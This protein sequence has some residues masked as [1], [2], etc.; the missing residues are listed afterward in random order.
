[1]NSVTSTS[2]VLVRPL[3]QGV[4]PWGPLWFGRPDCKRGPAPPPGIPD[5]R[6]RCTFRS[7]ACKVTSLAMA[8][9][10]VLE[11]D[12]STTGQD[13]DPTELNAQLLL[14]DGYEV[15]SGVKGR[16]M[17]DIK[18][19]PNGNNKPFKWV[20]LDGQRTLEDLRAALA[21]GYPVLVRVIIPGT[22]SNFNHSVL[23][24]GI[25]PGT[26]KFTIK[27]PGWSQPPGPYEYLDRYN[28][29]VYIQG[30]VTANPSQPFATSEQS[31]LVSPN[32]VAALSVSSGENIRLMLIDPAGRRT[33]F[34]SATQ[35]EVN[36]IPNSSYSDEFNLDPETLD[37]QD[38][39]PLVRTVSVD[40]PMPG[41]Y[42]VVTYGLTTGAFE[43]DVKIISATGQF[44]RK[45]I[46][47]NIEAGATVNSSFDFQPNNTNFDYDADGRA[48]L[49]VRRPADGNWYVLRGTAGYMVMTFGVAGDLMVP[50]D[51]DGDGKTDIAMFRPSNGT[52]Y[53]FNSQSQSFSTVGWGASGD[54]PV[55][56]DHDGDG[57]ADLVVFRPSTNTWY[58]RFSN[59]TF[60]STVFG[61][62]GDKPVVG[63]FDGDGKADIAVWRPSDNNWYILKTGFGFFVQTWGQAGDIP[64][65]ADYDGDGKT[66][67]AVFRPS[68]G[69]WFRIQSTAGFDTVNWGVTQPS[70]L[71]ER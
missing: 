45:L 40:N 7:S 22:G 3:F 16:A 44:K 10:F 41:T 37:P 36:E 53:T 50:A 20:D 51:Y 42:Q 43:L 28:N 69:Q 60:A 23:V 66:D 19:P 52:W 31:P 61:V 39:A 47:G 30:Y 11:K 29:N 26:G 49:S 6:L 38:S 64:V 1:M 62:A 4:A 27:D 12:F 54:L 33:G 8:L 59:G 71:P 48:D 18:F 46:S 25:E 65:P 70:A 34:D 67:V 21:N 24:T 2:T 17:A 63:D 15:E 56:A 68:T 32:E 14:N 55:P 5:T 35:Q 13:F 9:N 58:T 57:R